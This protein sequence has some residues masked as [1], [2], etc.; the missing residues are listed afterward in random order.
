MLSAPLPR[1]CVRQL[2]RCKHG[3]FLL[4]PFDMYIS[5]SLGL[6]GEWSED[7]V[8]PRRPRR[9]RARTSSQRHDSH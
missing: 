6:F 4:N 2:K 1:T 5:R 3:T 9:H 7:E 8:V